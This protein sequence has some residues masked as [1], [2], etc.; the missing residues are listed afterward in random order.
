MVIDAQRIGLASDFILLTDLR[1]FQAEATEDLGQ[2][3]T[4]N[5]QLNMKIV[6]ERAGLII[7]SERFSHRVTAQSDEII[8]VITAFDE[9]LNRTMRDSVEWA[10][11]QIAKYGPS[12]ALPGY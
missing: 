9:A 6:E 1:E 3:V 11:T 5:V 2:P 10:V 12:E 4:V 8:D 7:A